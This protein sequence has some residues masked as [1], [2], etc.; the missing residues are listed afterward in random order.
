MQQ[1]Y[2]IVMSKIIFIKEW[3]R[4]KKVLLILDDVDE[5][6][7]LK[8]LAGG[9]D[10][11]GRN[12][13]VIIT[14]RDKSLLTCH[15]IERIYEVEGLNCGESLELFKQSLF[16]KGDTLECFYCGNPVS[17]KGC[18]MDHFIPWSFVKDDQIWNL[19]F[20]CSH[21]NE[22]KNNRI[23]SNEYLNKLINR[24][25]KI[26]LESYNKKLIKL[27]DSALYN[28]FVRWDRV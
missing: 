21:C 11:F 22:S 1:K 3:L 27:Y 26:S 20:S 6:K 10:W 14:T 8:F 24:N 18:H 28:G 7:Q 19:V 12:S 17:L 5:L 2:K 23:P 9:F 16:A 15:G 13:R 25:K 4:R